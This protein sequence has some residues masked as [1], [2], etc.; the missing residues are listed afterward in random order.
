LTQASQFTLLGPLLLQP[1]ASFIA[2]TEAG[3]DAKLPPF[4]TDE[5]NAFLASAASWRT[6][7]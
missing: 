3:T 6:A 5:F 1:A 7:S 4:I 2:R